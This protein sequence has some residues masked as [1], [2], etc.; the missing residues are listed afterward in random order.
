[1]SDSSQSSDGGNGADSATDVTRRAVLNGAAGTG[2]LALGVG[3]VAASGKG[4]QSFVLVEDFDEDGTFEILDGP[5]EAPED[6]ELFRCGNNGRGLS[7]PY[8]EFRYE[9]EDE[10][11]RIYTRDNSI[12]TSVTYRWNPK[13]KTCEE[14]SGEYKQVGFVVD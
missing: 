3:G 2:A 13:D 6:R 11:R 12:D 14:A 7:F 9:G 1:M 5:F 10:V 8:W 4:G